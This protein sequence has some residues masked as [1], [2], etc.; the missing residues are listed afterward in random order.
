MSSILKFS[1]SQI[2]AWQVDFHQGKFNFKLLV[3]M[4]KLR[5]ILRLYTG[6]IVYLNQMI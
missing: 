1:F 4:D 2:W 5:W 6:V 3:L